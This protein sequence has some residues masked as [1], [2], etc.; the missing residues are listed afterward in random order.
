MGVLTGRRLPK[1]TY[2]TFSVAGMHISALV[3]S[4]LLGVAMLQSGVMK[5]VRPAWIREFADAVHLSTSQLTGLGSLQIA[6]TVGLI[7][8]IW[9]PPF[10]IAAAV[11]LVLYFCGAIGAHIRSGDRNMLGAV[12]F[13]ALSIATLV[14]LVFDGVTTVG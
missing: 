11:G 6:A 13:L 8:G 2:R 9:F 4:V 3:L 10:A 7:G 5:F 1:G 12:V 14:V